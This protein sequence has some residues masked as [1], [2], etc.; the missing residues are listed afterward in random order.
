MLAK[1]INE[2]LADKEKRDQQSEEYEQF[3]IS[4]EIELEDRLLEK[5]QEEQCESSDEDD[6]EVASGEKDENRQIFK[7]LNRI[8]V[9][10]RLYLSPE[11]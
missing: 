4:S 11:L 3:A 6:T 10:D 9:Q 1:L 8:V 5:E 7:E 2:K